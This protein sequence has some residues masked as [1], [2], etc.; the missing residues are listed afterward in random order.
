MRNYKK[1]SKYGVDQTT[2]GKQNRTVIDRKTEKEVCFDSLLEKR[3]Y[4]DI[5]CAGLDS[6]EIVDYELQKKYKLQRVYDTK[7]GMVDPSAKIKRK[8]MYYIYPDLDYVWIT[9]TK[10]TGWIDWDENEALKR[11][12]KK[13]GKKDG[14]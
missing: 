5:V 4:E 1:R 11:A 3:F 13:E 12:R 8:L 10:S 9:H 6:G 2:K 7:G 14:N